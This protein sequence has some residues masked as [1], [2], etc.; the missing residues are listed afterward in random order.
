MS[1]STESYIPMH[2]SDHGDVPVD[3][4]R[5][6]VV[7]PCHLPE[8]QVAAL[9]AM[10]SRGVRRAVAVATPS[11]D[12]FYPVLG[13]EGALVVLDPYESAKPW[14]SVEQVGHRRG[15]AHEDAHAVERAAAFA[16]RHLRAVERAEAEDPGAYRDDL[17]LA[18]ENLTAVQ[19]L[20]YIA[21][22]AVANPDDDT[23]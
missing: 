3:S 19:R 23:A 10:N 17:I 14:Q 16:E 18:R 11:G 1:A 6:L 22:R 7:D 13:E 12:G 8:G 5:L 21:R 15:R 4:G 20:V 9:T 2:T